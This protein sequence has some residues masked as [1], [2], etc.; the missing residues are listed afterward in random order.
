MAKRTYE[1][2]DLEV[3]WDSERCVH[4]AQCIRAL[5]GV[6]SPQERP[7][8]HLE[9]AGTNAIV[10]AIE[11]CPTGALRYR[12]KDG[13]EETPGSPTSIVAVENGPL[14]L[15]GDLHVTTS[16][17][18]TV[19]REARLALCRCGASANRPFCD[20]S[21]QRIGFRSQSVEP[22]A[23]LND[24]S[25]SREQATSP[26]DVGPQQPPTFTATP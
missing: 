26:V 9:A 14:V 1:S 23:A 18:A 16:D 22:H 12:R 10:A 13:G 25:S 15:R 21:H 4:V 17:G 8:I 11:R 7:W 24:S 19:T 5:P 3:I 2:N 20:G 6:F